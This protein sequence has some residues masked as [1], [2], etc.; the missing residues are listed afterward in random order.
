MAQEYKHIEVPKGSKLYTVLSLIYFGLIIPGILWCI[1]FLCAGVIGVI[2]G[3]SVPLFFLD[4]VPGW[5]AG[6]VF[7]ACIFHGFIPFLSAKYRK[8]ISIFVLITV[9]CYLGLNEL[10][11][12]HWKR[13]YEYYEQGAYP[14]AI[15]EF[16]KETE[17]WYLHLKYNLSEDIAMYFLAESYYKV[18][19]FDN[20]RKTY[21]M[22]IDRYN[23]DFAEKAKKGLTGLGSSL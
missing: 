4:W 13:G 23:G 2:R 11:G 15:E 5:L 20:A 19:D 3:Y 14:Q 7:S 9:L 6:L 12:R 16:K 8:A 21:E 18:G 22:M 10:Q 17:I 1:I